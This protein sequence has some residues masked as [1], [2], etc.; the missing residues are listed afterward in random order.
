LRVGLAQLNP[1]VGDLAGNAALIRE[2]TA[3]AAQQGADVVLFPE[4]VLTGCPLEDLASHP[5]FAQDSRER[6]AALARELADDG[7]GA[8]LV[9]LGC[10]DHDETGPR[11]AVAALHRRMVVAEQFDHHPDGAFGEHHPTHPGQSLE[12]LQLHGVNIGVLCGTELGMSAETGTTLA[13]AGDHPI[14]DAAATPF[15]RAQAGRPA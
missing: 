12:V 9:I 15:E 2:G 5:A 10:L 4:L 14:R 6:L 13:S 11:N 3:E 8:T 7:H 1:T